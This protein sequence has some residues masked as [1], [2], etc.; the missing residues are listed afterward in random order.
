[1]VYL[2]K[3]GGFF[4]GYYHFN[5]LQF[6]PIHQVLGLPATP[7]WWL[8]GQHESHGLPTHGTF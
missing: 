8:L 4:H 5:V 2:L 7:G 1:M 3:I 6:N